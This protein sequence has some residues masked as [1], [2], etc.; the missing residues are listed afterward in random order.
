MD[1]DTPENE[2]EL[3][4]LNLIQNQAGPIIR[5]RVM[6][7]GFF[8]GLAVGV[9]NLAAVLNQGKLGEW[10]GTLDQPL[11]RVF[12]KIGFD[13]GTTDRLI[14]FTMLFLYWGFIGL[15]AAWVFCLVRYGMA[16]EAARD[17]IS[18]RVLYIGATIGMLIGGLNGLAIAN[19]W[20][21]LDRYFEILEWPLFT[22]INL[23][24]EVFPILNTAPTWWYESFL[25]WFMLVTGYW[26]V[27][28]MLLMASACVIR[29]LV[30][31]RVP[32]V[33][34]NGVPKTGQT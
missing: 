33:D 21:E 30:R 12:V 3:A 26:I 14:P 2:V 4:G 28:G 16:A 31:R 25:I 19:G 11:W 18:R 15:G 5:S 9:L 22:L 29:A 32:K 6:L 24:Q 34:V 1:K 20:E 17:R 8:V 23:G 7:F 27:V 10:F 13:L